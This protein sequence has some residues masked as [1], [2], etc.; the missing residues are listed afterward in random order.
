MKGEDREFEGGEKRTIV[1]FFPQKHLNV[2]YVSIIF[3]LIKLY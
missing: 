2:F 3:V 1:G